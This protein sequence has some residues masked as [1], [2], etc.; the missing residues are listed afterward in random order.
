VADLRGY[1]DSGKPP[2]GANHEGYSKRAMAQDQVELMRQLGFETF[3][4]VGHDPAEGLVIGWPSTIRLGSQ[5]L[6]C[7]TSSRRTSC[8]TR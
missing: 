5:S 4:V 2:E 7:S 6:R 1:G 3:A 8:T